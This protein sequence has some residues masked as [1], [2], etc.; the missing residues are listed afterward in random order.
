MADK[1]NGFKDNHSLAEAAAKDTV[2]TK[3]EIENWQHFRYSV[4][5]LQIQIIPSEKTETF[6]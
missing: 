3:Q 2:Y 1:L 5:V 6:I 4:L